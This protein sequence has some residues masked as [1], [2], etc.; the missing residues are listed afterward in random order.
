MYTL[1][2]RVIATMFLKLG[3]SGKVQNTK[4]NT[5]LSSDKEVRDIYITRN[6]DNEWETPVP[7]Y[8]DGWEIYGC[9]VNG[10]KVV[11]NLNNLAVGNKKLN[12]RLRFEVNI[13]NLSVIGS[14]L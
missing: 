4:S 6:T 2:S 10:P 5:S 3:P 9:P 13:K 12:K 7:V 1:N 14:L 8:N 11:S